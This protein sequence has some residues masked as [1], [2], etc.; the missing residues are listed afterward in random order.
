MRRRAPRSCHPARLSP[1]TAAPS[2]A[3]V[4]GPSRLASPWEPP[5][6]ASHGAATRRRCSSGCLRTV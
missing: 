2:R 3:T 1:R 4:S 5:A 6:R